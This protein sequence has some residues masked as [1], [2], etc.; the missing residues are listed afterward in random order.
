MDKNKQMKSS[1]NIENIYTQIKFNRNRLVIYLLHLLFVLFY[2]NNKKRN[3][4]KD[5]I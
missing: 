1:L 2:L 5:I 3:I 4:K